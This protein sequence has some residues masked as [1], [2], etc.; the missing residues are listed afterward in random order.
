MKALGFESEHERP[1]RDQFINLHMHNVKQGPLP[2]FL[3]VYSLHPLFNCR[4][5]SG[6]YQVPEVGQR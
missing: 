3:N 4:G 6:V 2:P 1:D 5:R